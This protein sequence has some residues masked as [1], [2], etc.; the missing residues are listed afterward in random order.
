MFA[1]LSRTTIGTK[2]VY[3]IKCNLIKIHLESLFVTFL[4][5]R[6]FNEIQRGMFFRLSYD[7]I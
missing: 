4:I 5:R 6:V 2:L 3:G 7:E 1:V